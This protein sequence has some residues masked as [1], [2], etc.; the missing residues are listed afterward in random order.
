[1]GDKVFAQYERSSFVD[2]F[3]FQLSSRMPATLPGTT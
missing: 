1:L 2:Y 3:N